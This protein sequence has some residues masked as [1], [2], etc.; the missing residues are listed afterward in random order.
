ME[1]QDKKIPDQCRPCTPWAYFA[2][3]RDYP[4]DDPVPHFRPWP[5]RCNDTEPLIIVPPG[6]K[7]KDAEDPCMCITSGEVDLWNQTY[8]AVSENS[9]AWTK[10]VDDSWRDSASD[11]Q[12]TYETVESESGKWESSWSITS[13]WNQESYDSL[14]NLISETSSFLVTYSA[15]PYFNINSAFFQGNGSPEHPL[16]LS[17][18]HLNFLKSVENSLNDL[19][20][21][22]QFGESAYR[23]WLSQ[24]EVDEVWDWIE[25][26]NKVFFDVLTPTED[27]GGS[28]M[29]NRGGVYYQLTKIWAILN[30]LVNS[31]GSSGK[32]S[33]EFVYAPD[34]SLDN[35][36]EYNEA[37]KI[38]YT[39]KQ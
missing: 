14:R 18:T 31:S 5:P 25:Y 23:N 29:E 35:Y 32:G 8:S 10:A 9:A 38:Y 20:R 16:D 3:D 6:G 22:G 36:S 13:G 21:D 4:G 33:S 1:E 24:S 34:M 30:A 28:A 15:S 2:P 19:Y 26:F 12:S 11:W 27:P 17:E 37:G 7:C 39:F